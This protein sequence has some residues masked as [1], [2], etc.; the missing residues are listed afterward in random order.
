MDNIYI[1]LIIDENINNYKNTI[2]SIINQKYKYWLLN[3]INNGFEE[4]EYIKKIK[5]IK[6]INYTYINHDEQYYKYLKKEIEKFKNSNFNYFTI[7]YNFVYKN[8]YLEEMIDNCIG[9]VYKN[10]ICYN[11]DN[12]FLNYKNI[13]YAMWQKNTIIYID[14]VDTNY[15]N[16]HDIMYDFYLRT[17][18]FSNNTKYIKINEINNNNK[19]IISNNSIENYKNNF[20]FL[21]DIKKKTLFFIVLFI[22]DD[23]FNYFNVIDQF[24][25]QDYIN[26]EL[27]IIY[28]N[29]DVV[30]INKMKKYYEKYYN[31]IFNIK[32]NIISDNECLNESINYFLN[33]NYFAI[34]FITNLIE[35][36]PYY[37]SISRNYLKNFIY[38]SCYYFNNDIINDIKNNNIKETEINYKGIYSCIWSRESIIKLGF[39]D[40]NLNYYN[41]YLY[42]SFKNIENIHK[43][44]EKILINNEDGFNEN[45]VI[46]KKSIFNYPKILHLF[47]YGKLPFL[48]F[49]TLLSFLKYHENWK[50]NIYTTNLTNKNNTWNTHEQTNNPECKYDYFNDLFLYNNVEIINIDKIVTELK[51]NKLNFIHQSD[52]IRIYALYNYG[53]VWSDF[54]IIYTKNIEEV[55]KSNNDCI[56]QLTN[57][58]GNKY[59]PIG[60]FISNK[61][62]LFFKKILDK[63]LSLLNISKFGYETFGAGLFESFFIENDI[64]DIVKKYNLEILGKNNY[65]FF[66]WY[67][68]DDIY[69]KKKTKLPIDS[70]G[71]HW[72]NGANISKEYIKNFYLENFKSKS[73]I[74][75]LI[76]PYINDLKNIVK[77]NKKSI[78]IVIAYHNRLDLLLN[79]LSSIEKQNYNNLEIIIVNDN[80]QDSYYLKKEINNLNKLNIKIIDIT[81]KE[82]GERKNP[83][84][85]FNKGFKEASGEIIIIQNPESYHVGNI[86]D[87]VNINIKKKEYIVFSTFNI[88]SLEKNNIFLNIENKI[89]NNIISSSDL[90]FDN[91][92][93]W[94]T[95]PIFNS[96]KY[97]FCSAIY[98]ECLDNINYFDNEYNNGYCF[99]DDDLLFKVK[100]NGKY[101]INEIYPIN[102]FIVNMYHLP[103][104]ATGCE[105]KNNEINKKW[106]INKNYFEKKVNSINSNFNYP[107][108]M[109]LFWYGKLPL[110]NYI[111]LLSFI[112]HHP[113]WIIKIYT[114]TE[115]NDKILWDTGEQQNIDDTNTVDDYFYKLKSHNQVNIINVDNISKELGINKLNYIHQSDIIRIY[116]LYIYGGLWSDFDIIYIKNIETVLKEYTKDII[117]KVDI[118]NDICYY[119]IGLFLSNPNSEIFKKILDKQLKI[120]K[121]NENIKEYQ[122]FGSTLLNEMFGNYNVNKEELENNFNITVLDKF[123]YLPYEFNEL[124]MLYDNKI[125]KFHEN[126]F[127]IHW[128]N[129]GIQSKKYIISMFD[130]NR[131]KNTV[132]LLIEEYIMSL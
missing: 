18:I 100:Y 130:N 87:F 4:C 92:N 101:K 132:D 126:T 90:L 55:F 85:V 86:I 9:F 83:A 24:I 44:T 97:H 31:I 77:Q 68:L 25:I 5:Q 107:R 125:T 57:K 96:T 93:L 75:F 52:I 45:N 27:Y 21:L 14:N 26:F 7:L 43:I 118:K 98:K 78:S 115:N 39:F 66:E 67:E 56:F 95:H 81:E 3:I 64:N 127:G 73:T 34:T 76:E 79:T 84:Y 103:N 120:L 10:N 131:E 129:G 102:N 32:N 54:D 116:A 15:S 61:K 29:K 114:T 1:L 62:S 122:H 2:D 48:N 128:F 74:D 40:D 113:S 41:Q 49:I 8:D 82:K 22:K 37:L 58:C 80:S 105:N 6:Q 38:N 106:T 63:Q 104:I 16:I 94:Y 89:H 111:T 119:P 112:K 46:I 70:V 110:L 17:L 20:Q 91:D 121:S 108:I 19:Y 51:I 109:H 65:L 23:P 50:I 35:Y 47:W 60:M 28:N 36:L 13:E 117:F 30:N 53:G 124:D 33:N 42:R 123:Y 88:N 12:I 59:Y 69:I 99:D 71:I 11:F 72:F